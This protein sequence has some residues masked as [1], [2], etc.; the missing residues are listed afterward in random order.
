MYFPVAGIEINP[1]IPP[2]V[3]FSISLFTS[4]GGVSGAFLLLPF[5]ISV[6]GFSSPAVSATNY[7]FNIVAIPGGV[8]RYG[9]EGR[10]LWPLTWIIVIGTLPGILIGALLRIRYLTNPEDFKLFVGVVLLYL[11]GKLTMDLL[12]KGKADQGQAIAEER[13]QRPLGNPD[14][15]LGLGELPKVAV[16]RLDAFRVVYEFCDQ[17]F[18]L[19]VLRLMFLSLAVGIVGGIYG[20][21]GGAIIAPFLVTFFGIAVYVAAGTA[22]M[23]TFITSI[24]GVGFYQLLA[25]LHPGMAVSPDWALGMLFGIGGMAGMYCGARL[26]KFVPAR[27]VKAVLAVCILLPAVWYI[28]SSLRLSM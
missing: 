5:Q 22:L 15:L 8:W 17:I 13:F 26:Q 10:I 3:T 19:R 11:G 6:F 2:V 23:G 16:R 25:P 28:R 9:R 1:W 18:N 24:A 14:K 4:M 27:I 20:L 7:L 21:G 12:Q